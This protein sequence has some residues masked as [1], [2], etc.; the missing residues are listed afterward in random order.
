MQLSF[1]KSIT[2]I[3]SMRE[4]KVSRVH[5]FAAYCHRAP[6]PRGVGCLGSAEALFE[7]TGR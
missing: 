4:S 2:Y 5:C 1:I 3:L 7:R 6:D